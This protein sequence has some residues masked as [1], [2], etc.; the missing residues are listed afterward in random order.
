IRA[1]QRR[2]TIS[3]ALEAG[4][5]HFRLE[6][7]KRH[8]GQ[9]APDGILGPHLWKVRTIDEWKAIEAQTNADRIA[10]SAVD[11]LR[12]GFG[13]FS[14]VSAVPDEMVDEAAADGERLRRRWLS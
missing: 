7:P 3:E 13:A 5:T 8:L 6:I 10:S 12:V 9:I 2:R 14:Y 1:A 4:I 11:T